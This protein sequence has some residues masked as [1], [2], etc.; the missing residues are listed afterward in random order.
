[1]MRE[2][3]DRALGKLLVAC[4]KGDVQAPHSH[5]GLTI[6]E[7]RKLVGSY[8]LFQPNGRLSRS[9]RWTITDMGRASPLLLAGR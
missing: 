5:L 8:L 6:L 9:K 7:Q 1:M 2:P 4:V 3:S